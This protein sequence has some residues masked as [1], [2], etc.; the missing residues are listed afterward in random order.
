[1]LLYGALAVFFPLGIYSLILSRLNG[2]RHPVLVSGPGDFV[3]L[4]AAVSGVFLLLGPAILTGFRYNLG[5]VSLLLDYD[6]LHHLQTS[7]GIPWVACWYGYFG[8]LLV[9]ALVGI[10]LRLRAAVI[11]NAEETTVVEAVE[12]VANEEGL[13]ATRIGNRLAIREREAVAANTCKQSVGSTA[14]WTEPIST[15]VG[16]LSAAANGAGLDHGAA[17][18][19][20]R[21]VSFALLCHVTLVWHKGAFHPCRWLLERRLAQTLRHRPSASSVIPVV[22]AWL[23]AVTLIALFFFTAFMQFLIF[24]ASSRY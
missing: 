18:V 5:D 12:R 21:L 2:R 20:V 14:P 15:S 1:V 9:I 6:S 10:L 17:L 22:F 13:M 19:V 3:L 4:L 23:S 7:F 11:Y 16:G 8:L 24:L